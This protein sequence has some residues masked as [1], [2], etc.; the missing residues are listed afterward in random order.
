MYNELNIETL[1]RLCDADTDGPSLEGGAGEVES[2]LQTVYGLEFDVS[3]PLRGFRQ[4][5][6]HNT[7]VRHSTVDKEVRDIS[8]SRIKG[9]VSDMGSIRRL[10]GER[11]GLPHGVTT[12]FTVLFLIV[13]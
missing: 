2:L 7:N 4:L 8:R 12:T 1:T 5:I 11:E 10:G 9:Q 6:F 3:E 13:R